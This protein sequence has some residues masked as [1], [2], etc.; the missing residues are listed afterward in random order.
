VNNLPPELTVS[1]REYVD[2][3]FDGLDKAVTKAETATEKRFE[4][5][6]E[7]RSALN[8][9]NRLLMPRAEAERALQTL[10]EKL[11]TL[12]QRVNAKD[13][14]NTG[15]GQSWALILSGVSLISTLLGMAF[16]IARK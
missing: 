5:V 16:L 14:Q 3:R 13:D 1:L 6:N 10:S 2:V 7:F 11:D 8:D 12:T 15:K 4:S 9:S